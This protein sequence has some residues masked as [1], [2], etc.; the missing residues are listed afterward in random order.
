[1]NEPRQFIALCGQPPAAGGGQTR[2]TP[3]QSR[4]CKAVYVS[5]DAE[6]GLFSD[7]VV[8]NCQS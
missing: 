3:L 4:L 5:G 1:L 6:I 2:T 8:V 7:D